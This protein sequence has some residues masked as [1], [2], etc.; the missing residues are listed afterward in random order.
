MRVGISLKDAT[1][2]IGFRGIGIW[3]GV[4]GADSLR[5]ATKNASD[6][7]E[8]EL[9][10]DCAKLRTFFRSDNART[11]PL[12]EA[13]NECAGF[14]RRAMN[15][16]PGT[17][18]TLEGI[19]EPFKPLLD[20]D[21][22]RAYLTR[23]CPVSFEKGFTYADTVNRFLRKN[24]P[25][26]RSVRV[27]LDGTPVR[28]LHVEARTQQPILGTI[29]SPGAK[30]KSSLARYWMCHPKA[31]GRP[32]EGYDRGLRIRVRNFVVVQPESLRAI[33]EQRGLKSLHLYNYWVGEIHATHP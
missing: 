27:L 13:L 2:D 30:T 28:G 31:V 3:A 24:V 9:V 4:A 32:E 17:E 15:R 18:V 10:V 7:N 14:R 19:I 5:V 33:L 6:P 11:K 26:Y 23:E 29:D 20:S 12:I 1:Q 16:A 25:G 21:A 8:Y 22:V